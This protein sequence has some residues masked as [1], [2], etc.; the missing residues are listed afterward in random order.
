M[1]VYV[2]GYVVCGVHDPV[3]RSIKR[4]TI[5]FTPFQHRFKL[6][7][8]QRIRSIMRCNDIESIKQYDFPN[9]LQERIPGTPGHEKVKE[10]SSI[11]HYTKSVHNNYP[12][13][14]NVCM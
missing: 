12:N 8:S 5:Y 11:L 14:L 1:S 13:T 2:H 6:L 3:P 10:V 4:C 9:I 7:T